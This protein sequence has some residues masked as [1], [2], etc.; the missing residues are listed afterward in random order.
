MN[1]SDAIASLRDALRALRVLA[2]DRALELL[3]PDALQS[4]EDRIESAWVLAQ[5]PVRPRPDARARLDSLYE[6]LTQQ[7][8]GTLAP[9]RAPIGRVSRAATSPAAIVRGP[10][11]E[12]PVV[13]FTRSLREVFDAWSARALREDAALVY[14][15]LTQTR[16]RIDAVCPERDAIAF[17]VTALMDELDATHPRAQGSTLYAHAAVECAIDDLLWRS[18]FDEPS[19][20]EPWLELWQRGAWPVWTDEGC[21]HVFVATRSEHGALLDEPLPALR[22]PCA[23]PLSHRPLC[24]E[25]LLRSWVANELVTTRVDGGRAAVGR[26]QTSEV[27][28]YDSLVARRHME[29]VSRDG[30]WIARDLN[31]TNGVL[32]R[33]EYLRFERVLRGGEGFIVGGGLLLYLGHA[34]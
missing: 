26:A 12:R 24:D 27:R 10:S 22:E 20:M 17:Y 32:Y 31:S 13:R 4:V 6:W 11:C 23:L 1:S 21:A 15:P 9:D 14:D 28:M 3:Q 8:W 18:C 5:Q 16:A 34:Q 19:P 25:R 29:I 33:G 30:Q 7:W 2:P